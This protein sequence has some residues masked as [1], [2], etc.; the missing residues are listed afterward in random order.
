L[1][2]ASAS[3]PNCQLNRVV[4]FHDL[5][6]AHEIEFSDIPELSALEEMSVLAVIA[7]LRPAALLANMTASMFALFRD[8]AISFGLITAVARRRRFEKSDI[9][10][11]PEIEKVF[12]DH[13][14]KRAYQ[15]ALWVCADFAARERIRQEHEPIGTLL[16]YP[17]CCVD[18]EARLNREVRQAFERAI[19]KRAGGDPAV[20]RRALREDWKVQLPPAVDEQLR[21]EHIGQSVAAFPFVFHVACAACLADS[22][23]SPSARLNRLYRCFTTELSQ[24]ISGIRELLPAAAAKGAIA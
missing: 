7:G 6:H 10:Y 13:F 3:V 8:V 14:S 12:R 11:P 18:E 16:D 15:P 24:A 22:E 20:L 23:D 9:A 5:L 21:G 17:A 19:V 2:V 1:T 4:Q